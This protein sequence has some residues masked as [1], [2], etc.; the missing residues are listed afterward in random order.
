M[1]KQKGKLKAAE[2]SLIGELQHSKSQID[3]DECIYGGGD[4]PEWIDALGGEQS[5]AAATAADLAVEL[6][7][8]TEEAAVE[9]LASE[10][11]SAIVQQQQDQ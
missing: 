5:E 11:H 2:K 4:G 1:R 10:G 7:D 6:C 9:A 3:G 8:L